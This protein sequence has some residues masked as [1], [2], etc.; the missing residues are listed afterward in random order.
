VDYPDEDVDELNLT[1]D[2]WRAGR[3]SLGRGAPVLLLGTSTRALDRAADRLERVTG[4]TLEPRHP[5]LA[6]RLA[7]ARDIVAAGLGESLFVR[8]AGV[9]GLGMVAM[10]LVAF[11]IGLRSVLLVLAGV[12]IGLV[13]PVVAVFVWAVRLRRNRGYFYGTAHVHSVSPP[14]EVGTVGRAELHLSVFAHGMDGVAVRIRDPAVPVSKWPDVGATLPVEVAVHNLR[15]VRVLWD[16][17]M[18]HAEAA[19]ENLCAEDDLPP[20]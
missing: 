10:F 1:P 8:I 19:N 2:A 16:R 7:M 18:T 3:A 17:V 13:A 11:G 4:D 5:W 9:F 15:N 14:P 12:V 6:R 20:E